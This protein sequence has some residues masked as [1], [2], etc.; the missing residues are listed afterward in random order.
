MAL[1]NWSP[2]LAVGVQEIDDQHKVL[3]ELVNKL[4]D[5]MHA[6][7]GKAALQ[8][9]LNELVRYTQYHFGTEERLMARHGYAAAAG[10]KG[11][12]QKFIAEVSAFKK[13]FDSGNAMISSEIMNFL[14]DWLARHILGSDKAFAKSLQAAGVH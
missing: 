9:V 12:H 3:V 4:N 6:G 1:I 13:K 11:E 2:M 8:G 7:Q 5:A 10:H 14:R